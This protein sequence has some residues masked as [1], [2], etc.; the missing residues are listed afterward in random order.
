MNLNK[1]AT[2]KMHALGRNVA[3]VYEC[4]CVLAAHVSIMPTLHVPDR[5]E[6]EGACCIFMS[7]Y[8]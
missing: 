2:S 7:F 4:G 6:S 1:K 8:I 5:Y 3:I